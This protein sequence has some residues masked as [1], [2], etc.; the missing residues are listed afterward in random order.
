[1]TLDVAQLCAQLIRFDTTN[2][3][4]GDSEGEREAAEYVATILQDNGVPT[5]LVE[6]APRRTNVIA[7]IHGTDPSLPALLVQSHLDV[8]PADPAEWSVD[9][10]AGEIRDGF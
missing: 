7:R 6:P 3:G 9:P 1:M 5:C 10:F 4:G 2:R 8:V